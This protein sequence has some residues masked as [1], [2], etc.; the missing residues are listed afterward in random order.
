[1][2]ENKMVIVRRRDLHMR[3]GKIAAQAGH[4]CVEAVLA[5]ARRDGLAAKLSEDTW[6]EEECR[7]FPLLGWLSEG[8]LC[9]GYLFHRIFFRLQS[10]YLRFNNV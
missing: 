9:F 1:M 5:A 3:K 10:F 4:A 2:G 7:R 6:T 8:R